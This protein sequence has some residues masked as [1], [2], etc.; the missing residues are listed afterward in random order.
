M[1]SHQGDHPLR[2]SIDYPLLVTLRSCLGAHETGSETIPTA[3]DRIQCLMPPEVYAAVLT[4]CNVQGLTK[5]NMACELIK[6]GLKSERFSQLLEEADPSLVVE[7][8]VDPRSAV[9]QA[10]VHRQPNAKVRAEIDARTKGIIKGDGYIPEI[11][12]DD[13]EKLRKLRKAMQLMEMMDAMDK[14]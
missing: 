8:R 2:L 5:S 13:M 9:R 1:V 4:L 12:G 7:P 10:S 6:E 11:E 3:L 14:L